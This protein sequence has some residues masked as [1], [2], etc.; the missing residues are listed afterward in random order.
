[1]PS[2]LR[3]A[4][5][6]TPFVAFLLFVACS[7]QTN[8]KGVVI[9]PDQLVPD[10]GPPSTQATQNPDGTATKHLC[11]VSKKGTAGRIFSGTLLLPDGP[12]DGELMIDGN[13]MIACADK[14]CS[15]T[16]GYGDATKV[17]CTEVVISPGLINPH[18]HIS[19]AN[20]PPPP[21]VTER[22]EQRHDW[23]KGLRGHT[24]IS[25]SAPTVP[26]A[27]AAAELRFI[28]SGLTS[29]ASGGSAGSGAPGLARNID[30]NTKQL[31]GLPITLAISD[32]FPLADTNGQQSTTCAGFPTGRKK[33]ADIAGDNA[34]M[35]H[36]AEGIDEDAHAEFLCQSNTAPDPDPDH[37]LIQRNVAVIHGVAVKPADIKQYRDD[38][39]IL[40]WSPRSNVSLYGN[41]AP[42]GEY[43]RLGVPITLGT[44]WLPSGSMNFSRELKCADDLNQKYFGKVLTDRQLWQAV[45]INAAFATGTQNTIGQLKAGWVADIAIFDAS[46]GSTGY[47][48][49]IDAGVED[50]LLVLRGGQTMYGDSEIVSEIGDSDCEDLPVCKITKKACVAKDTAAGAKLADLMTAATAVYP[51]FYCK[52]E[53][54]KNEPTCTPARGPTASDPKASVYGGDIVADDKDG[55]G[56]K[57]ADDNCPSVFNPIRPM[58]NGAQGDADGDS[59]GDACDK[60]PLDSGETCTPLDGGDMDGDG[61]ANEDDNCPKDANPDQKDADGDGK[62]AVC[63]AC[64]DKPNP[65][66]ALCPIDAT[67]TQ[68]RDPS[69]VGHPAAGASHPSVKGA[70]VTA[71]KNGGSPAGFWVQD[72]TVQTF[73]GLFVV[74]TSA[75]FT[76]A[77]G[78]VV[79]VD[80]DYIE[81]DGT[82]ELKGASFV[83]TD[84]TTTLNIQPIV[85]DPAA[86]IANGEPL[87]AMLCI[88]NTEQ[89]VT[90]ENA[91]GAAGDFDEFAVGP[92]NLRVDDF[93]FDPL[94][95]NYPVGTKFSQILGICGWSHGNRKMWPRSLADIPQIP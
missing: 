41:T 74:P 14:D 32:T 93:A 23:R 40:I 46:K 20:N 49:V 56:I 75:T 92:A 84:P 48:A 39:S 73:G 21:P 85:I 44:D 2:P 55:D 95:N 31:E 3:A 43:A 1:M 91:D 66:A 54:P 83:I 52:G 29:T 64:D 19:F 80:G 65:G 22:Y 60:C 34:Y 7:D 58:D 79:T 37:D 47:R 53:T 87:E 25:T 5:A 15:K 13:G 67:I 89:D 30:S 28:M 76:V 26:N 69:A 51:L 70:V 8:P 45:T 94:D 72:P 36:I 78:N 10:G 4:I 27:V 12:Q 88:V 33:A 61:V 71:V 59:I 57:D 16:N 17:D 90:E 81:F 24:K 77:V 82:S 35:P 86:Y 42:I 18:D 50:T 11:K 63:D 9:P 68:I 6:A 38:G 62:G